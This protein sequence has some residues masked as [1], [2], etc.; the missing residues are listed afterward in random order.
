MGC[1]CERICSIT[2]VNVFCVCLCILDIEIRAASVEKSGCCVVWNAAAKKEKDGID[3]M[4]V[5]AGRTHTCLG[6]ELVELVCRDAGVHPFYDL[7]RNGRLCMQIH[8]FGEM[9]CCR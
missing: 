3:G 2:S 1:T 5:V 8:R 6:C 4:N 9:M 7:L